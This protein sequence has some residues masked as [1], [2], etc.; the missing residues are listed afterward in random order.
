MKKV[1]NVFVLAVFLPSL[2][3]AY[4]AIRSL[5]DQQF[6][7]ERQQSLLYQGIADAMAK[8]AETLLAEKQH[9]FTAQVDA[10]VRKHE[11]PHLAKIFDQEIRTNW[12][13]AEIGFIV[14]L[15]GELLSPTPNS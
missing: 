12:P 10:L 6:V 11:S 9:E 5:R 14:T 2:I 7:S 1:V 15:K 3:L 8:E 4:L 13:L